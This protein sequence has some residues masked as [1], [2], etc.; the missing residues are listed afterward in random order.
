LTR[1]RTL[2]DWLT[3]IERQHP[4]AVALG[5]DRVAEV[6]AR[7]EA[8]PRCPVITVGGTNGKGS[9]CALLDSI[10][11]AAGHRVGRYL[12]PHLLRY[13]ERVVLQGE[14]VEDAALC[15]AFAAVESAR[16]D[17]PLTYFEYGTLAAL[18]LF[19]RAELDV[20]VLEVGLGGRLDAVNVVDA[21]CAVI[22][23]IDLDHQDYLGTSREAIGGEKAGIM[24][25]GR[26]VVVAD[27]APP[28]SVLDVARHLGARLLL[29]GRDFGFDA[30]PVQWRYRAPT[31][32]AVSLGWPAMRGS[33]QLR[34]A[35]AALCALD[36]LRE[37]LPVPMQAIRLGLARAVLPGRFEVL[38]GVP[39][40]ILD[41]A[42]NAEAARVLAANLG[43]SGFARETH[44]VVGM[45]RD[46]D[47][48]AVLT[49]LA[50]RVTRWYP[51]SLDGP[52]GASAQTLADVL[53]AAGLP[54][55]VACYAD[56]QSAYLAAR[57]AAGADD[58]IIVFGSFLTV[59]AVMSHLQVLQGAPRGDG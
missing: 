1:V 28:D 36:C 35:A 16:S 17:V 2:P 6:F 50:G 9:T 37:R 34:N 55:P 15:A 46:K 14:E 26:P 21:D 27:P 4:D 18:W 20:L 45:L 43:D 54:V 51:C 33:T 5:L 22:T 30:A 38:P 11:R 47:L 23:S 48:H 7:L 24:R 25:A 19:A 52:R 8:Q 32:R 53:V 58:R 3:F 31:G 57:G 10:L 59:G 56:P 13:N 49:A 12:S 41:V 29:L 40:V 44:A 42:H 39:R